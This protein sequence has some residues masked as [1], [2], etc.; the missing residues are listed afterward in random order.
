MKT[1]SIKKFS[2]YVC[3]AGTGIIIAAVF[4]GIYENR[5]FIK[6]A[7]LAKGTVVGF[8]EKTSY[9][10]L[11]GSKASR[12][13]SSYAPIVRFTTKKGETISF[14]SEASSALSIYSKG[15]HV[16]VL[17]DPSNPDNAEINDFFSLYLGQVI[18]GGIGLF[19][20]LLGL[21]IAVIPKLKGRK[22]KFLRQTGEALET[23]F[24]EV[25]INKNLGIGG[26]H[27]YKVIT[28]WTDPVTGEEHI[29]TSDNLW[30][31]PTGQI[32]HN[33]IMVYIEHGNPK[34]FFVDLSFLK[35]KSFK[36][37]RP[38]RP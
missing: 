21:G 5:T 28:K 24:H 14:I 15:E 11:S 16:K 25:K 10:T 30:F 8:Y 29:F 4:W 2:I 9:Y 12:K 31:N 1:F 19:I 7:H 6:N 20:V 34:K 13:S 3:W 32:T 37:V 27:P 36:G 26:R 38:E 33:K 35:A 22:N 17:Y 23:T 18:V